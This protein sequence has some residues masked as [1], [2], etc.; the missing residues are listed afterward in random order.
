MQT[1]SAGKRMN[2][3]ETNQKRRSLPLMVLEV[4]IVA[5]FLTAM[6]FMAVTGMRQLESNARETSAEMLLSTLRASFNAISIWT[7][8]HIHNAEGIAAEA[9]VV[10]GTRQ[11]L[12][13]SREGD[14]LSASPA[15]KR[16]RSLLAP[17]LAVMGYPNFFIIAPDYVTVGS[18][19]NSGIGTRNLIALYKQEVLDAVFTGESRIVPSMT[20]DIPSSH[21]AV[22]VIQREPIM[23]V[24]VPIYDGNRM[25][26]VLALRLDPMNQLSRI[27]GIVRS[28]ASGETYA[29][30]RKGWLI[31][32]SRF[33]EQLRVNGMIGATEG[34][35]LNVKI[36]D[37]G[38]NLAEGYPAPGNRDTLPLTVMAQSATRGTS[39]VDTTGYRDYRGVRVFGAWSWDDDLGLGI[40]TEIDESEALRSYTISRTLLMTGS[41]VTAL[42]AVLMAWYMRHVRK[43]A[44]LDLQ[45]AQTN[46]EIRI[47]ERTRELVGINERLHGEIVERVRTEEKLLQAR[48]QLEQANEKLE[49]LALQDGLTGLANRR[50]FNETLIREWKRCHREN[51]PISLLMLDLDSFKQYNDTYGHQAGDA[52]LK[53]VGSVLAGLRIAQRPGDLIARYGGEEFAVI[54]SNSTE[55]HA[56]RVARDILKEMSKQAIPHASSHVLGSKIVTASIG[57]ATMIP[58][59]GETCEHLVERADKALYAAKTAGRNRFQKSIVPNKDKK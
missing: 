28:G 9:G 30:D 39:G 10:E 57:V 1:V 27:L 6:F 41:G 56:E 31:A 51:V 59:S 52:C 33:E 3:K 53:A 11:L 25:L 44:E 7:S 23:F 29:F 24:T 45:E 58:T 48:N 20:W 54:L 38:G 43:E 46:L 16:V 5:L 4:G 34:S 21:P 36:V 32:Q 14:S 22:N 50:R 12:A 2:E 17:Q 42:L 19:Q 26:A 18:M 8:S 35:M 55:E 13:T 15:L 47:E 40:A 49:N 37:P